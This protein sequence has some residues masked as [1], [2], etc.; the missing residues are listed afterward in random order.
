MVN[1]IRG[2]VS[3]KSERYRIKDKMDYM[4]EL[5]ETE[6]YLAH[7]VSHC[8]NNILSYTHSYPMNILYYCHHLL[9]KYCL[10]CTDL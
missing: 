7:K 2:T 3:K 1:K 5:C 4:K 8:R 9:G 6:S 10:D